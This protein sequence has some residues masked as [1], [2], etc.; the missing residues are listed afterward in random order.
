MRKVKSGMTATRVLAIIVMV[1]AKLGRKFSRMLMRMKSGRVKMSSG[2]LAKNPRARA[3]RRLVMRDARAERF[4][5][6]RRG[7]KRAV[8]LERRK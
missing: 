8:A 4:E 1:E 3:S 2:R 5:A 7:M 6:M